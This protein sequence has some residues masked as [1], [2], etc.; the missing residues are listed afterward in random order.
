M[1]GCTPSVITVRFP[2]GKVL[3]FRCLEVV[4]RR[5][6]DFVGVVITADDGACWVWFLEGVERLYSFFWGLQYLQTEP[7]SMQKSFPTQVFL[8]RSWYFIRK[9]NDVFQ[10]LNV[11]WNDV[12]SKCFSIN[13]LLL[14]RLFVL[15]IKTFELFR[16]IKSFKSDFIAFFTAVS[17]MN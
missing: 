5:W 1:V 10:F 2:L 11:K 16:G 7:S 13:L 14:S 12:A 17:V 6:L 4:V 8:W 3:A 9:Y 15:Q